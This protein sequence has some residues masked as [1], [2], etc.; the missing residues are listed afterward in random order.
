MQTLIIMI[1][2][3]KTIQK[4]ELWALYMLLICMFST[5]CMINVGFCVKKRLYKIKVH[6]IKTYLQK[7]SKHY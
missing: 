4:E 1:V 7:Q 2:D 5:D 3:Q 6:K